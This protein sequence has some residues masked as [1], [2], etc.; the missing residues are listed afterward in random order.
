MEMPCG[1]GSAD[2]RWRQ[3]CCYGLKEK[4]AWALRIG[5]V[6][7]DEVLNEWR[8]RANS[9][10]SGGVNLLFA[11]GHTTFIGDAVDVETW[12]AFG[13]RSDGETAGAF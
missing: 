2:D 5:I 9:Q 13:A 3:C 12:R 1:F 10:H 11:D 7:P 8:A 4:I 6:P